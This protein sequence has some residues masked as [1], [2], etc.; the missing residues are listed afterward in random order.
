M[1][2]EHV[3]CMYYDACN[4]VLVHACTTIMV[5]ACTMIMFHAWTMITAHACTMIIVHVRCPTRLTFTEI[6]DGGSGERSSPGK[7]GAGGLQ[8]HVPTKTNKVMML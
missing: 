1:C 3:T 2:V 4:M 7:Q 6:K 8:S 5:H